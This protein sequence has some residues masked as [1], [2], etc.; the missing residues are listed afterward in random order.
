MYNVHAPIIQVSIAFGTNLNHIALVN[1]RGGLNCAKALVLSG[2]VRWRHCTLSPRSLT[3]LYAS[4]DFNTV[5]LPLYIP[6]GG[7]PR[8]PQSNQAGAGNF[9][10]ALPIH[11][12]IQNLKSCL[13]IFKIISSIFHDF[14]DY[15]SSI[16]VCAP[17]TF[18]FSSAE[19]N[20]QG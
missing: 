12:R 2:A 8:G 15:I 10:L 1:K 6:W 20:C 7:G 18:S 19:E 13:N 11:I 3:S 4:R 14:G 9:R 16:M 5:L 17:L